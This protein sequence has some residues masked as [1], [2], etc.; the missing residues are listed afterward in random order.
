MYTGIVKVLS[1]WPDLVRQFVGFLG[2][3]EALAAG[4]VRSKR[5]YMIFPQTS[6]TWLSFQIHWTLLKLSISCGSWKLVPA[7]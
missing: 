4:A 5:E 7:N 1:D 6:K 2:P 3:D